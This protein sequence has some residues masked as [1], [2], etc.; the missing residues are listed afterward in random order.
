MAEVPG[1]NSEGGEDRT[2]L[3]ISNLDHKMT[4]KELTNIFSQFGTIVQ[5]NFPTDDFGKTYGYALITY[6]NKVESHAAMKNLNGCSLPGWR[7]GLHVKVA[8]DNWRQQFT[9][10]AGYM[11]ESEDGKFDKH[12]G[13]SGRNEG[14]QV[15]YGGRGEYNGGQTVEYGGRG[16]QMFEAPGVNIRGVGRSRNRQNPISRGVVHN[17]SQGGIGDGQQ[18]FQQTGC[19]RSLTRAAF[20]ETRGVHEDRGFTRGGSRGHLKRALAA[21]AEKREREA[22]A[23][24]V[25]CMNQRNI[26]M[27]N[28]S[29]GDWGHSGGYSAGYQGGGGGQ[30]GVQPAES[31]GEIGVDWTQF[32]GTVSMSGPGFT[33]GGSRGSRHSHRVEGCSSDAQHCPAQYSRRYPSFNGRTTVGQQ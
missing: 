29:E 9:F 2:E 20:S 30:G 13:Q 6:S 31:S 25:E 14:Q 21:K 15:E 3:I 19:S 10:Y 7:R 23:R 26:A 1:H 5:S 22:H 18:G 33:R 24:F 12:Q 27:N 11:V 4:E 32:N 8:E 28:V 17:T 16:L